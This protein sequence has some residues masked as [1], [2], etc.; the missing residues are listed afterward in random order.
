M[1]FRFHPLSL[2]LVGCAV[3]GLWA[4]ENAP[5]S[6]SR[7]A[8]YQRDVIARAARDSA[9]DP[10]SALRRAMFKRAAPAIT[11]PPEMAIAVAP[12][13]PP[14]TPALSTTARKTAKTETPAPPK[15][16]AL[17]PP[18]IASGADALAV[19]ELALQPA[20]FTPYDRYLGTVRSVIANVPNRGNSIAAACSFMREAHAFRYATRDPYRADPPAVTAARREGDCKSKALWLYDQLG[21]P[22]ALYVIGKSAKGAKASHAWVYWRYEARWWILDPTNRATPIAADSIPRDRYVPY[23]SFGKDGAF[24]HPATQLLLAQDNA[25]AHTPVV[26]AHPAKRKTRR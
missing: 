26:A 9:E 10:L 5:S 3:H 22:S 21:D 7:V 23:Y 17:S 24:R 16:V 25:V 12:S 14:S 4:E 6:P 19:R 20:G 1:I 8:L 18:A 13:P 2:L 15:P 11:P